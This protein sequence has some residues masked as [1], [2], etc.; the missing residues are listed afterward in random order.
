MGYHVG[1]TE[2]DGSGREAED[3]TSQGD[4]A[5]S[6]FLV[7]G[8]LWDE[9]QLSSWLQLDCWNRKGIAEPPADSTMSCNLMPPA[10]NPLKQD[11]HSRPK[12][13]RSLSSSN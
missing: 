13:K 11:C 5:V 9:V 2:Q 6:F 3:I 10:L 4:I 1:M 7:S 8:S 12:M